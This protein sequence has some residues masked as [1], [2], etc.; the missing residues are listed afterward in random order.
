MKPKLS[1]HAARLA[2]VKRGLDQI[3]DGFFT[4]LSRP[5]D[6]ELDD[7]YET[8]NRISEVVEGREVSLREQNVELAASV[9]R[10]EKLLD[11][12]IDGIALI[13]RDYSFEFVN[14]RFCEILGLRPGA[15]TGKKLADALPL[16]S[17]TIDDPRRLERVLKPAP[18]NREHGNHDIADDVIEITGTE[19]RYAQAY[20]APVLDDDGAFAGRII[21][22][23]DNTR[24]MEL[25]RLKTEFI[26]VVSHELRT[27]LTSIKGYTDLMLSGAT[28]E[29]NDIQ[30]EF[31][32]IL[33]SSANRLSNL[34]NDI[35][36]LS[37]IDAG[38]M[39]VKHE[40]VDYVRVVSDHLRLMKAAADEKEISIDVSFP[41]NLPMVFGDQDKI[42]QV[43]S[44]LLSNAIK[45]TPEGGWIK[46]LIEVTGETTVRT[47]V[48]D[49]GIGISEDDQK[50]LFQ[51]FFR[52]DN[53]LTREAGG[54]GLG[55][56]IVKSIIEMLGGAIWVQSESG[57]GSRFYY[58]LPLCMPDGSR[59]DDDELETSEPTGVPDR[60]LALI[61]VIDDSSY[62]R[63][64]VQ[65][66]LHRKGY[67]VVLCTTMDEGL[68]RSRQHKPDAILVNL[69]M[70]GCRGFEAL[71]SLR[72]DPATDMLPV[73][74]FSCSGDI[75]SN[76]AFGAVSYLDN[77]PQ[78]PS[79]VSHLSERNL[80]GDNMQLALMVMFDEGQMPEANRIAGRL[81]KAN[82][83]TKV[84]L[85]VNEAIVS[86]VGQPPDVIILNADD[87]HAEIRNR[88]L[89][90][91]KSETEFARIP[92]ILLT[93]EF[94]KDGIHFYLG[95]VPDSQ[96][97]VSD[98]VC[99]Q[100]AALLRANS[101]PSISTKSDD[102]G[103]SSGILNDN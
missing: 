43:V 23:H 98:Y 50:R 76:L 45:Y 61:L 77:P 82:V 101:H 52:A 48:A 3:G 6:N 78:L 8:F 79:L 44:N 29:V 84:V 74:A 67:G 5:E 58:T 36:D 33:Q 54:T 92:L 65:H 9:S 12:S 88:F 2:Q 85:G 60:G 103:A 1:E 51:K 91:V 66:A 73:V 10:M 64:T 81:T 99:D 21:S 28:G 70:D 68:Q 57:R 96:K 26:S 22:L 94:E 34:I 16:W 102:E 17:N 55:L 56:V 49:S 25:D 89:T 90:A 27:P 4:R 59:T 24:E 72:T 46:L 75:G 41:Q 47:C 42:S 100:V 15:L 39:E 37:R 63:E 14:R 7:L 40:T 97:P 13:G 69:T 18:P 71:R 86:V 62:V 93:N 38:R 32:G 87:G 83:K 31:L 20:G 80:A 53:S 19:S 95:D 11:A 30:R 35:L